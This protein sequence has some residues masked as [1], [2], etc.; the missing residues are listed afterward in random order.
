MKREKSTSLLTTFLHDEN[1]FALIYGAI[2]LPLFIGMVGL[3]VEVPYLFVQQSRLQIAADSAAHAAAMFISTN[4]NNKAFPTTDD[5]QA[6]ARSE[7]NAV[8]NYIAGKN[9]LS[10]TVAVTSTYDSTLKD[11]TTDVTVSS[12]FNTYFISSFRRMYNT[13]DEAMKVSAYS[14]SISSS[15]L[16]QHFCYLSLASSANDLDAGAFS[17]NGS[18]TL[19]KDGSDCGAAINSDSPTALDLTGTAV[20]IKIPVSN[21]GGFA[22]TGN[23]PKFNLSYASNVVDPY[24]VSGQKA[25]MST[26]YPSTTPIDFKRYTPT[27]PLPSGRYKNTEFAPDLNLT[28]G[29]VYYFD[30]FKFSSK[31]SGTSVSLIVSPTVAAKDVSTS[32]QLDITANSSGDFAGIAV[33]SASP[34]LVGAKV[35]WAGFNG[36]VSTNFKG[37]IYF[38]NSNISFQGDPK[39]TGMLC[40]Q[41]IA[42]KIQM[43][44]NVELV[45]T[46][47]SCSI[48]DNAGTSIRRYLVRL[49]Q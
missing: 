25:K 24:D 39:F 40:A 5:L 44:G 26:S 4:A 33:G 31:V 48:F 3:G 8:V 13:P 30:D 43:G 29:G 6:A 37:A 27:G 47:P 21:S 1:G 14:R 35:N 22:Y 12:T 36:G 32:G 46:S 11:Y 45:D 23:P 18:T 17:I 41:I 2:F 10:P 9:R 20:M 42:Q 28:S 38:P 7:A 16:G 49:I 15:S 19:G 34:N